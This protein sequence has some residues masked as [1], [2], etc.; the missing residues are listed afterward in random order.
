MQQH[1]AP[2]GSVAA[3]QLV[4][5]LAG[6]HHLEAGVAHRLAEQEFGGAVP[7]QHGHFGMPHSVGIRVGQVLSRDWDLVVGRPDEL[8]LPA[9]DGAFVPQRIV[10]GEGIG[11]D[12]PLHLALRKAEHG[13]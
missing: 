3:K 13:A 7:V 1:I 9:R 8:G 10:E 2:E 11:A 5:A 12:R 4:R 6:E